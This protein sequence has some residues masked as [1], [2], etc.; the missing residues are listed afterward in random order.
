[1]EMTVN[2]IKRIYNESKHKKRQIGILADLNCCSKEEIEKILEV[3]EEQK[4]TGLEKKVSIEKDISLSSVKD[5]L[6]K[7]LDELDRLIKKSEEEYRE[8]VVTIKVL[9]NMEDYF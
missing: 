5:I 8:I 2:E 3:D 1:M 7:K 6:F 4:L 9:G